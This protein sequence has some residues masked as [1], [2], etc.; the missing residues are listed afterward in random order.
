[1]NIIYLWWFLAIIV[2]SIV[3]GTLRSILGIEIIFTSKYGD[4]IYRVVIFVVSAIQ[5]YLIMSAIE[6]HYL[7]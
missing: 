5:A 7:K 1:M 4:I 2:G 3:E 6:G